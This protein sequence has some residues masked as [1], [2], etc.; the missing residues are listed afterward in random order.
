MGPGV[1]A[2][3][4]SCELSCRLGKHGCLSCAFC[5]RLGEMPG[6]EMQG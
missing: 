5:G 4:E 2:L 1:S 6:A 3:M